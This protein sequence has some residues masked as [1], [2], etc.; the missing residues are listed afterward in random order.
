MKIAR[1]LAVIGITAILAAPFA[2][3]RA[4]RADG[5]E[6]AAATLPAAVDLDG[7]ALTLD[8]HAKKDGTTEATATLT[9]VNRCKVPVERKVRV[10]L[11]VTPSIEL[12]RMLPRPVERWS[13]EI[14]LKLAAGE[15][16]TLDLRTG[17][18]VG[19]HEIAT[20]RIGSGRDM[21]LRALAKKTAAKAKKTS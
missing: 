12:A 7:V 14:T 1:D 13:Q 4:A 20:F 21:L 8:R 11:E 17:V 2:R 6:R 16:K 10:R 5:E 3:P 19:G 15:T 18:R 9:A